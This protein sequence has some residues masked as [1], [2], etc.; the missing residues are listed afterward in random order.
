MGVPFLLNRHLFR[1][2]TLIAFCCWTL[3][4]SP[5]FCQ[6]IV[7]LQEGTQPHL[8][9]SGLF[10]DPALTPANLEQAFA[11]LN[12]NAAWHPLETEPLSKQASYGL[13]WRK[14]TIRNPGTEILPLFLACIESTT[15]AITT[16][17]VR[18]G[19]ITQQWQTG[20]RQAYTERPVRH[21]QFLFP[22]DLAPG[23]TV[24]VLVGIEALR[25]A[26]LVRIAPQQVFF[27]EDHAI[28]VSSATQTGAIMLLSFLVVLL[29]LVTRNI[30]IL[31]LYFNI[32]C[33]AIH[34]LGR[35]GFL[36]Q[37]VYPNI[38]GITSPLI[39]VSVTLALIFLVV[40]LRRFLEFRKLQANFIYG[41]SQVFLVLGLTTAIV[42]ATLTPIIS[43]PLVSTFTIVSAAYIFFLWI[44]SISQA[45]EGRYPSRVFAWFGSLYFVPAMLT[46]YYYFFRPD[47][48]P[49]FWVN[50]RS[51][52][53]LFALA[54]YVALLYDLRREQL[55][56]QAALLKAE[57]R[58]QF[59]ATM[60]HELRTPL[61]GVIGTA[62]LLSQTEQTPLQQQYSETIISSGNLLLALIND[63]LDL[64]KISEGKLEFEHQP[65][66][67]DQTLF[68][69]V[70][71]FLPMMFRKNV[72]I[73]VKIA[74]DMPNHLI[75]DEY[76][77]RQVIYNLL[78]NAMKF[79]D[80]G[81]VTVSARAEKLNRED[82]Y[83]IIISFKDT[84]VGIS[85]EAT[86]KIFEQ[87]SQ[88]DASTTRR[89]GGSGLGLTICKA[90]LSELGGEI[91]VESTPDVGSEFTIDYQTDID[92]EGENYRREVLKPLGSKQVLLISDSPGIF[93][94]T[95]ESLKFWG[96]NLT[97]AYSAEDALNRLSSQAYD[98]VILYFLADPLSNLARFS[99]L[100]LS[101][102]AMY[103]YPITTS[104]LDW[105]GK[106]V[107]LPVPTTYFRVG[108]ALTEIFIGKTIQPPQKQEPGALE[109]LHALKV[110][111]VEDNP[112]NKMVAIGMLNYLG[113]NADSAEN[114]KE[115]VDM[116]KTTHY[117]L[118]FMDCEM[119]VL[120]G[121]QAS[122]EIL[123]NAETPK[124]III[125]LTAQSM[126]Y[127]R[128]NCL[129]A[130]MHSVVYKPITRDK[131]KECLLAV[132]E[133]LGDIN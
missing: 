3:F 133:L 130:G 73:Y 108:K 86:E 1:G 49:T 107:T 132:K 26:D 84:G 119:P 59:F 18:D 80:S 57:A 82:R 41:T 93:D 56:K 68:D 76:R 70:S 94:T 102:L 114:G 46:M 11:L 2:A 117:H 77:I 81:S 105:Q 22:F 91:S 120:D 116:C 90:I 62:E 104:Q 44:Y 60:N 21:R 14:I 54:L 122:R 113:L 126:E 23:E 131:L 35:D 43:T 124:P 109:S 66:E 19:I 74:P 20:S 13:S 31:Y 121:Y 118:I 36:D 42:A 53:I 29:Y 96:L 4:T 88:A 75:G 71:S 39:K 65:Y 99:K 10:L 7:D 6:P 64:T 5:G 55:Q 72:L 110:L 123:S 79:T 45:R 111:V 33:S 50:A 9:D 128:K 52:E 125:A 129:E 28:L 92:L 32:V 37:F 30:A 38:G 24:T 8:K 106:L 17:I 40:F 51:G 61:N 98:A 87:F 78:N 97:E 34:K 89:Y 25:M 12:D 95:M 103:H 83:K 48:Q 127:A 112:T 63:I 16:A 27:D 100:G 101:G 69:C 58:T 67:L 115:A 85:P 47:A 15:P